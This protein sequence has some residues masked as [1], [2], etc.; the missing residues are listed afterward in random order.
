MWCSDER[1]VR[2]AVAKVEML[3]NCRP[4]PAISEKGVFLRKSR[5][6]RMVS[7]KLLDCAASDVSGHAETTDQLCVRDEEF[8]LLALKCF[9]HWVSQLK[10]SIGRLSRPSCKRTQFR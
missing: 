9:G 10:G 1:G 3:F 5:S 2:H 6:A 8:I 7:I 4:E